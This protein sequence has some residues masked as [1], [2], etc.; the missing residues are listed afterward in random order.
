VD[1][2]PLPSNRSFGTLFVV[3]FAAIGALLFWKRS[4]AAPYLL[5]SSAAVLL[6]TLFRPQAL[7][8]FNAAWM[9]LAYVLHL[10]VSP[11]VLGLIFFGVMTPMGAL[12]RLRGHDPM[13]RVTRPGEPS[14]WIP[15][16]PPGPPPD[17]LRNQF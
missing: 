1:K 7:Q 6:V 12:M 11:I 4:P 13:R 14:Y 9:R 15:R 5:L 16:V 8:P 17:S 10:I 2:L 3:V